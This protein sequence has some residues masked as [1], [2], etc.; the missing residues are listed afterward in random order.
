[1]MDSGTTIPKVIWML[2]YQG[3]DKAPDLVRRCFSS[4]KQHNPDWK[5]I[6]LDKNNLEEY[7]YIRDFI[8]INR[9]D[10]SMQKVSNLIRINLL[11]KYG[12]IWVD[13]TCFC[14]MPLNNWLNPYVKS[15]FFAFRNPGRDR[16]LC[17][18]F[19]VSS[20]NC[21]LITKLCV[22]H[23]LFWRRNYFSNQET[24]FGKLIIKIAE[25]FLNRNKNSTRWWLSFLFTKVFK[26]YP[27]FIFHYH[28]ANI[29]RKDKLS[30]E[31]WERTPAF[32]A[33]IPHRVQFLGIYK[34]ITKEI[35]DEIDNEKS[36]M[37]KLDWRI[38]MN[39]PLEGSVLDYI[40]DSTGFAKK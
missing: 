38:D 3:I 7:I 11:A 39:R 28:T 2:W 12:G 24:K 22:E 5:L 23:N 15:G 13:A 18:W 35:K 37:Y 9:K 25:P 32:S 29:I 6:L 14:C 8:D 36:P 30:R 10:I 26:L 31:I 16:I 17:N 34:S 19:L 33:D 21:H 27:Y 20:Q 4:W 40:L 1:M